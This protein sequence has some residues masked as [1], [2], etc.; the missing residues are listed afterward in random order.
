M[1]SELEE[2]ESEDDGQSETDFHRFLVEFSLVDEHST[3][4]GSDHTSDD[5]QGGTEPDKRVGIAGRTEKLLEFCVQ[6][7]KA[8]QYLHNRVE[9]VEHADSA[10]H[11]DEKKNVSFVLETVL[12][13]R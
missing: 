6:L 3:A 12:Q 10:A 8:T 2:D 7:N 9:T 1:K 13:S 11:D 5:H 4:S